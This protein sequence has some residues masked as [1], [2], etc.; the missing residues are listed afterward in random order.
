V[1]GRDQITGAFANAI[2]TGYAGEAD[3]N[4]NLII[5]AD[6]LFTY[7]EKHLKATKLPNGNTITPKRFPAK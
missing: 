1:L 6:A 7:L 4:R 5:T 3:V 2:S